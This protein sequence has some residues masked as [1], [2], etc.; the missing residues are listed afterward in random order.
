M[1]KNP[2]RTLPNPENSVAE[3]SR[4]LTFEEEIDRQIG[5]LVPQASRAQVVSRITTVMM[6][7]QFAGPI[8]HPRHLREYELILPGSAD[9]IIRMAEDRN[10]HIIKTERTIVEAEVA[11][12]RRGMLIGAGLFGLIIVAA[13]AAA[14]LHLGATI[15]GMFLGAAV[16]GG[17]GLFIKGRNGP[18][19][20]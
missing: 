10:A 3:T 6:S 11:D 5:D 2:S 15:V 16:I 4:S 7:E 20:N 13:F 1:G 14:Y 17:I 9:R 19:Q 8:A 18:K 12:Q